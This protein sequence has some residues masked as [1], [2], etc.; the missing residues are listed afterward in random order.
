MYEIIQLHALQTVGGTWLEKA[1]HM[2]QSVA[3]RRGYVTHKN[4]ELFSSD[5]D[6][7]FEC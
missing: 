1:A 7:E 5:N 4:L 2:K 6:R 3:N